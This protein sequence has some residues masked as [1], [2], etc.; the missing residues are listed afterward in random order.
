MAYS[1][2]E[3]TEFESVNV[4]QVVAGM[5]QL[6]R[7]SLTKCAVLRVSLP[8]KLPAVS[9]NAAQLRQVVMNLIMNASEAIGEARPWGQQRYRQGYTPY[10]DLS[11]AWLLL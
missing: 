6:L 7:V 8:E 2:E 1:G 3:G 4:S 5:L 10:S 9:A 11:E